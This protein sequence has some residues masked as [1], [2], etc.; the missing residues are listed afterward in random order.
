MKQRF[1]T[2]GSYHKRV[3][4]S[5]NGI[6]TKYVLLKSTLKNENPE[7]FSPLGPS[8]LDFQ[9]LK[10]GL[11]FFK[12]YSASQGWIWKNCW[13]MIFDVKFDEE[14]KFVVKYHIY[15]LKIPKLPKNSVK[16]R[17]QLVRLQ[18]SGQYCN[19]FIDTSK[20]NFW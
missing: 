18:R 4:S 8:L 16:G 13:N 15:N 3:D 12:F 7:N 1:Y 14:F 11:W 9:G 20:Y 2:F 10:V 5:K 6:Q 19:M 17:N